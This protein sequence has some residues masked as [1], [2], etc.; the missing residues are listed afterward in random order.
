ME[1]VDG[2]VVG[3]HSALRRTW[4]VTTTTTQ[5]EQGLRRGRKRR[6]REVW[7]GER[8]VWCV[9]HQSQARQRSAPPHQQQRQS[10]GGIKIGGQQD[11]YGRVFFFEVAGVYAWKVGCT[12]CGCGAGGFGQAGQR[13]GSSSG[14]VNDDRCCCRHHCHHARSAPTEALLRHRRVQGGKSS[15]IVFLLVY[16]LTFL[17]M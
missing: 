3:C 6:S 11:C 12:V 4:L 8:G 15:L 9:V 17:T 1:V 5:G 7:E 2:N 14:F 13:R 10:I 16:Y